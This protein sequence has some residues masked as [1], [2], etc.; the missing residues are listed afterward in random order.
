VNFGKIFGFTFF[1]H[2][3]RHSN[4]KGK[5]ERPFHYIENNF[6]AGREFKDWK[7]LNRACENWCTT[8]A[9]QKIKQA[10]GKNP[11]TAFTQEKPYLRPLPE[12]LPPVY[13]HCSRTV[14]S[15]GYVHLDNNRYSVPERL[16]DKTVD[17]YK[18]ITEVRIHYQHE[19]VARHLREL[20]QTNQRIKAD[21]HH[22]QKMRHLSQHQANETEQALLGQDDMLD[23]YIAE[24]KTRLRGRGLRSLNQL[25]HL[26][27]T[28]PS[29]A[30]MAAIA[31]AYTYGLYDLNRL[32]DLILKHIAGNV[33]NLCSDKE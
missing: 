16:I 32:E 3:I 27:R 5:I 14:D 17:V 9:N 20:N 1:A 8:Y 33:F 30:F 26:K 7:E 2:A 12:I 6:L 24:F 10:L 13:A 23:T 4:R 19:E 31:R 11:E 25:L 22:I 21:G 28:Y 18:Y 15:Q 29:E